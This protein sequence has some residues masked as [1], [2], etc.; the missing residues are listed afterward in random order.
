MRNDDIIFVANAHSVDATKFL[1]FV[2]LVT[3]TAAGTAGAIQSVP[4]TA[5]VV[6]GHAFGTVFGTA[7]DDNALSALLPARLIQPHGRGSFEK[8]RVDF[9]EIMPPPIAASAMKALLEEPVSKEN[10]GLERSERRRSFTTFSKPQI[11]TG[12]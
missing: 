11:I 12:G 9:R 4:I 2:G 10:S 8:R 1:T 5:Q 3:A 7:V 6:Q